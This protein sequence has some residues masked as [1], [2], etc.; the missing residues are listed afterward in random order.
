MEK[1]DPLDEGGIALTAVLG[2]A[3]GGFLPRGFSVGLG[4]WK[5][6]R[7]QFGDLY[8][9]CSLQ[10]SK[11]KHLKGH[12]AFVFASLDCSSCC[13]Q[14][15][16]WNPE[17]TPPLPHFLF[18][19]MHLGRCEFWGRHKTPVNH[20]SWDSPWPSSVAFLSRCRAGDISLIQ[21]RS[22]LRTPNRRAHPGKT[23]VIG[24][25]FRGPQVYEKS[26]PA[27]GGCRDVSGEST[28]GRRVRPRLVCQSIH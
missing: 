4:P 12:G 20:F 11:P 27:Y 14:P 3:D 21:A 28:F 10:N 7:G 6:R 17:G 13:L 1:G 5:F 2:K 25:R 19:S 22:E 23:L 8:P 26:S 15:V 24:L 16:F 18:C 9:S